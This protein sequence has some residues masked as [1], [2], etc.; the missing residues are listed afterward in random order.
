MSRNF[1]HRRSALAGRRGASATIACL[2]APAIAKP[3]IRDHAVLQRIP[4]VA[5]HIRAA[6]SC[7]LFALALACFSSPAVSQ[8]LYTVC[9]A[10]I[11]RLCS[12]VSTKAEYV[13]TACLRRN[14]DKI[15]DPY[16]RKML[17]R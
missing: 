12:N 10:D 1:P 5:S 2:A 9:M 6:V 15:R 7:L 16:C 8:N 4:D 3:P 11:S 13:I 17:A 14:A